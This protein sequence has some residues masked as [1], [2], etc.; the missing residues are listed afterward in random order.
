[1]SSLIEAPPAEALIHSR[2]SR[3]ALTSPASA[4]SRRA[5]ST[6]W[7]EVRSCWR[8]FR[9]PTNGRGSL[10]AGVGEPAGQVDAL[11][12]LLPEPAGQ[13]RLIT[14]L[15]KLSRSGSRSR[16]R[17]VLTR[18]SRPPRS[19][20]NRRIRHRPPARP[21][22]VGHR[23]PWGPRAAS[24]P[25]DEATRGTVGLSWP[26]L[27]RAQLPSRRTHPLKRGTP[28]PRDSGRRLTGSAPG[29]L[30]WI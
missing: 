27:E 18:C 11:W 7:S 30:H 12:T 6:F 19:S 13:L 17:L 8:L 21:A 1:M 25:H 29:P 3:A 20:M 26:M 24:A 23:F 4:F 10:C 9:S 22:G 28:T 14:D 15:I 2:S 5:A 16:L